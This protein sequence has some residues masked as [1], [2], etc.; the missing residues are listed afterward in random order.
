MERQ[1][2][3]IRPHHGMCLSFFCG[4]GYS[5]E[6]VDNMIRVRNQLVENPA[7]YIV[8]WHGTDSICAACPENRNG[9]CRS[10]EKTAR[11]DEACLRYC[12]LAFGDVLSWQRFHEC[13]Q[14]KILAF[15]SVRREIC[16]GCA[17]EP[18]CGWQEPGAAK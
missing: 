3:K 9:T 12:G 18:I 6:F 8:L 14:E 17:W 7:G 16:A 2:L 15:P 4:L 1:P 13:V 5:G 11:Y 10:A